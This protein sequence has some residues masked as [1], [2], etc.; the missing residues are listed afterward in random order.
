MRSYKFFFHYNKPASKKAGKP[1]VSVHYKGVCMIGDAEKLVC[2]AVTSGKI[3]KKQPHFVMIGESP[4]VENVDG[5]ITIH[6]HKSL[7]SG[8]MEKEWNELV[9]LGKYI[10]SLR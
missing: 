1:Q 9:D 4:K 6:S 10:E 2:N 7:D 5:A 8:Q 3:N